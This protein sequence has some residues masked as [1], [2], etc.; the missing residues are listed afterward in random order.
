MTIDPSSPREP[1]A[2]P[3][4]PNGASGRG[5]TPKIAN[6]MRL[7]GLGIGINEARKGQA[8]S[9]NELLWFAVICV[10]GVDAVEAIL[11]RFIDRLFG[12]GSKL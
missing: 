11:L 6:L 7:V 4:S 3:P 12:D 8:S 1:P 2:S 5:W 9:N 10:V